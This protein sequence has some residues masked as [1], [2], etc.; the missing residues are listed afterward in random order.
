MYPLKNLK[1]RAGRTG[2]T[3]TGVTLAIAFTVIMFSVGE[4]IKSSARDMIEET[5]IELFVVPKESHPLIQEFFGGFYL[6]DG[7]ELANEMKTQN[8]MIRAASPEL[9]EYV[10]ISKPDETQNNV[11]NALPKLAGVNMRGH[12]P[13]TESGFGGGEVVKGSAELPTVG[14]P[15]YA[16][17]TFEGGT[18]SSN[19]THEILISP[20]LSKT[21][22]ADVGD[23][24]YVNPIGLETNATYNSWLENSTWFEVMGI[25]YHQHESQDSRTAIIHLSELQY[26]TGKSKNDVVSSIYVDLYD[27]DNAEEVKSWLKTEYKYK[28]KIEVATQEEFMGEIYEL[29]NVFEGFSTMIIVITA[30]IALLFIATVMMISVRERTREIGVLKAIGISNTT[31]F[32]MVLTESVI[33]CIIAS[34]IGLFLGYIGANI[35][36]DYIR[37]TQPF[38]PYGLSITKITPGLIGEILIIAL[39]IG[40]TAGL[41]PA[42]WACK[43][44]PADTLRTE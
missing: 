38:I 36:E 19:F 2:L 16:N 34:I 18:R 33:L 28:D 4:G 3:I 6:E 29:M 43:L 42:F 17:G 27:P 8:P 35:L 12:I 31:I 21:L 40:V 32:K 22:G 10:Y 15:F 26:I 5:G 30:I 14:D 20:S 7:R 25:K 39:L 9:M 11:N 23:K 41:L 44:N 13:L 37:S 1:R 24:L